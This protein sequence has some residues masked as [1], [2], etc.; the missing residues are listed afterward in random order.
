VSRGIVSAVIGWS[1][2]RPVAPIGRK[3]PDGARMASSRPAGS[4]NRI[5]RGA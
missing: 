5:M 2:D 1:S 4:A 3:P